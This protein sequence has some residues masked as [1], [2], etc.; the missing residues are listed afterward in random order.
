MEEN[1]TMKFLK[2]VDDKLADI[3]FVKVDDTEFSVIYERKN[4]EYGYTQRLV[5]LPKRSGGP[6]IRSYQKDLNK[7]NFNNMVGL[8]VIEAELAVKKIQQKGWR[9]R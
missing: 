3:G 2:S 6:I 4:T 1:K 5:L 8:T 9:S 7:S